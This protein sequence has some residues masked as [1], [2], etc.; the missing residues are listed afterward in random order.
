MHPGRPTGFDSRGVCELRGARHNAT[1]SEAVIRERLDTRRGCR[2]AGVRRIRLAEHIDPAEAPPAA[3]V[4]RVGSRQ[5]STDLQQRRQPAMDVLERRR[6]RREADPDRVGRAEVGDDACARSAPRVSRRASGW[7]IATWAPRRAGSRGEPSEQPSGA[8]HASSSAI[9]YSVRAM[10]F[11]RIASM[12]ASAT[13]SMPACAAVS[14]RIAG[15]PTSQPRDARLALEAR[16]PSRTGRAARTSPG[17]AVGARP[18]ARAGRRGT[19]ARRG[20]RSGTCTCS[21]RRGRRRSRSRSTG[22][23]PAACDRSHRTS[24]PASRAASVTAAHVDDRRRAV[25][26]RRED[27]AAPCPSSSAAATS[28]VGEAL[29]RVAV[30]PADLEVSLPCQ[31]LDDVPVRRE[32]GALDDDRP[33]ARPRVERRGRDAVQVDRRRVGDRD[34]AGPRAED[35]RRELVADP[36][37]QLEPAVVPAPDQPRRPR[38]ADVPRRARAPPSSAGRASCR[39]GRRRPARWART[40]RGSAP[41]GRPRRARAGSRSVGHRRAGA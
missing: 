17:S 35:A 29:D 26:D 25:V 2:A 33:P 34:L 40:G 12:P 37:R 27:D 8:S 23:E 31:P 16:A 3:T 7:R 15:V 41:A 4:R 22:I 11:A 20:R 28:P 13:S 1:E 21:R 9:A 18:G 19:R 5:R 39:R 30:Q 14:A 38:L 10:P 36:Q 6:Q 32:L 24:A